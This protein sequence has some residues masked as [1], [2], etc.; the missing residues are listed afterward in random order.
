LCII[1]D[2]IITLITSP[3][4]KVPEQLGADPLS[5]SLHLAMLK[6]LSSYFT[7]TCRLVGKD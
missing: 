2:I 4:H 6:W 1:L 5:S 3:H 7:K